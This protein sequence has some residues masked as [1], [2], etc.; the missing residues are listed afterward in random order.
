MFTYLFVEKENQ[1]NQRQQPSTHTNLFDRDEFSSVEIHSHID[2]LLLQVEH[3]KGLGVD[4][5]PKITIM[6][7][8]MKRYE[9][10]YTHMSI[11]FS[12]S[13]FEKRKKE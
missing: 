9:I 4:L 11:Y 3:I 5:A 7:T 10:A 8:K 13:F 6:T 1:Q 2:L 12:S